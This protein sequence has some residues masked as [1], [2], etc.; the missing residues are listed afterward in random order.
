MKRCTV[1]LAVRQT[2]VDNSHPLGDVNL[3]SVN[4]DVAKS[5]SLKDLADGVVKWCRYPRK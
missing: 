3:I 5:E 2:E 1:L 4:E